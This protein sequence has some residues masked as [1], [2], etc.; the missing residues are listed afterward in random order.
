L[1][2]LCAALVKF[3]DFRIGARLG[4]VYS[5]T[6]P[7][8]SELGKGDTNL[9]G[10]SN[11]TQMIQKTLV[12][13]PQLMVRTDLGKS[14]IYYWMARG[15]FPKPVKL[16][17]RAVAWRLSDIEAWEKSRQTAGELAGTEV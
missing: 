7:K 16:S 4:A 3:G 12:R 17:D 14:T 10:Q 15:A 5:N 6:H 11:V 9:N 8:I 2:D 1:S 13:L